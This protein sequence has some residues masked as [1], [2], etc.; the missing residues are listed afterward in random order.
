MN[1]NKGNELPLSGH[2]VLQYLSGW[3]CFRFSHQH[4][5]QLLKSMQ[6]T[7]FHVKLSEASV[8]IFF[9]AINGTGNVHSSF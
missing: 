2:S 8:C 7:S 1:I 5:I 9:R 3:A 6:Y 4:A